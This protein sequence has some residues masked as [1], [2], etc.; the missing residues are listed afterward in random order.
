MGPPPPRRRSGSWPG[1]DLFSRG[2]EPDHPS[3][4][5]LTIVR[6]V[7]IVDEE[8]G[9]HCNGEDHREEGDRRQIAAS[10]AARVLPKR[11]LATVAHAAD[12]ARAAKSDSIVQHG[13]FLVA[14]RGHTKRGAYGLSLVAGMEKGSRFWSSWFLQLHGS[15]CEIRGHPLH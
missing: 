8:E 6:L 13:G 7:V 11:I 1:S 5:R 15:R 2:G 4:P 10:L 9:R 14:R 3:T 12:D